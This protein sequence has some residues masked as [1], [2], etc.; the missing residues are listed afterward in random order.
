MAIRN[1]KQW[2]TIFGINLLLALVVSVMYFLVRSYKG[3]QFTFSLSAGFLIALGVCQLANLVLVYRK[4]VSIE[5]F[6]LCLLF[7]FLFLFSI[8]RTG[9]IF[10]FIF[11]L[12]N[13]VVLK[14]VDAK[15]A[16]K[17]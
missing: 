9:N 15:T 11:P 14:M 3:W 13:Y 16:R 1:I 7:L 12:L 17:R 2:R 6:T 10:L 4:R 8:I 5:L